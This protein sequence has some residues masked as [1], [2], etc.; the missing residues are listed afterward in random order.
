MSV[1]IPRIKAKFKAAFI[2]SGESD[3]ATLDTLCGSLATAVT[4]E[5]TSA[6]VV[7]TALVWPGGMSPAPVTGTGTLT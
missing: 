1:S 7:P 5:I 3:S 4:E 6:T 2:A